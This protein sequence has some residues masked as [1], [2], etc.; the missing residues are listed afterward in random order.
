MKKRA[1]FY[2]YTSKKICRFEVHVNV[3]RATR[4][5]FKESKVQI[6]WEGHKIRKKISKY[7]WRYLGTSKN[8]WPSR[9]IWTLKNPSLNFLA[10]RIQQPISFIKGMGEICWFSQRFTHVMC[11]TCDDNSDN[12][13]ILLPSSY[14]RSVDRWVGWENKDLRQIEQSPGEFRLLMYPRT[15]LFCALNFCSF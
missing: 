5:R 1:F 3:T 11:V 10:H 12:T 4:D 14:H 15:L 8:L 9:N 2:I 6:F 13:L 7:I